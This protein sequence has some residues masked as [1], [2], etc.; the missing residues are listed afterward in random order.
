MFIADVGQGEYEEVNTAKNG[1]GGQNYGWNIWEGPE[2]YNAATCSSIGMVPPSFYYDHS[3]GC[4]VTGG[5]AYRGSE[6]PTMNGIYLYGDFCE[7][8]IWG[9]VNSAGW[10]TKLL[11]DSPIRISTFGEDESGN[12]Y[13]ADYTNGVI[14]KII[15]P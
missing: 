11:L 12:L 8:R 2:C 6:F 14:Y 3:F 7:G 10:Q 15:V 1:V 9:A 13:A 4:S 5:Y